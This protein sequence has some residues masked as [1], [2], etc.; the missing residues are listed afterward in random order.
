MSEGEAVGG[1]GVLVGRIMQMNNS[2]SGLLACRRNSWAASRGDEALAEVV[3]AGIG[4]E[5]VGG[6][7]SSKVVVGRGGFSVVDLDIGYM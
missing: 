7:N 2:T 3:R 6:K 1:L 4:I 5:R